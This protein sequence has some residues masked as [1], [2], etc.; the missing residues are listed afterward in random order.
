MLVDCRG[1]RGQACVSALA[2]TK[3]SAPFWSE[4]RQ[5]DSTKT[6]LL[7]YA[8]CQQAGRRMDR[9]TSEPKEGK[10]ITHKGKFMQRVFLKRRRQS[11]RQ[12]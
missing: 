12:T 11:E 6:S 8:A 3:T 4:Q 1:E 10:Q 9:E 5:Q 7:I 2:E